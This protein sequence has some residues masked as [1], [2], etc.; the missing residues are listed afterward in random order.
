M[1]IKLGITDKEKHVINR[2]F[3]VMLTI[4]NGALMYCSAHELDKIGSGFFKV[5]F[6]IGL[7][8]VWILTSAAI[9]DHYR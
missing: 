1:K 4:T 8:W 5:I 2:L 9:F 7:V 6:A 3:A